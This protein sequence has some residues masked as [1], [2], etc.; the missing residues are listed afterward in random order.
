[1]NKTHFPHTKNP[2]LSILKAPEVFLARE[3]A[4]LLES[5]IE[6][7]HR[8]FPMAWAHRERFPY[9]RHLFFR[10][11]NLAVEIRRNVAYC[12][13]KESETNEALNQAIYDMINRRFSGANCFW[14][15][16]EPIPAIIVLKKWTKP[17]FRTEDVKV[18][19][20][21]LLFK[22][23]ILD[24]FV[25][26]HQ[27]DY[28]AFGPDMSSEGA[29]ALTGA[30]GEITLQLKDY[31]RSSVTHLADSRSITPRFRLEL[32]KDPEYY[33]RPTVEKQLTQYEAY[34]GTKLKTYL[35]NYLERE[36]SSFTQ[37][38]ISPIEFSLKNWLAHQALDRIST[39]E[40]SIV[41]EDSD[42]FAIFSNALLLF[43]EYKGDILA[44]E[45]EN[46]D[47]SLTNHLT[48]PLRNFLDETLHGLIAPYFLTKYYEDSRD[49]LFEFYQSSDTV[50]LKQTE[51][52]ISDLESD[53]QDAKME[54]S[55]L[56]QLLL[57]AN[58][59]LE[60]RLK[61]ETKQL[62]EVAVKEAQQAQKLQAE[63][64]KANRTIKQ[65]TE[66][67]ESLQ[68]GLD[69][70][71]SQIQTN[72]TLEMLDP[73][74]LDKT[75]LFVGGSPNLVKKMK[76]RWPDCR[77]YELAETVSPEFLRGSRYIFVLVEMVNHPMVREARL[78]SPQAKVS[79]V[80][81]TNLD[82]IGSTVR[83]LMSA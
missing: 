47:N 65:L 9:F 10:D 55:A 83:Q 43:G 30:L 52:K 78:A 8:R 68:T 57:R 66:Q 37:E 79:I 2:E 3:F 31:E 64:E 82:R 39:K 6:G 29:E 14:R 33:F 59:E 23:S 18:P 20:L 67:K 40:Q 48:S 17:L 26:R 51:Q 42:A 45:N 46:Y 72:E 13:L 62:K 27:I 38:T 22:I 25:L 28:R 15:G 24:Y 75:V 74:Y 35:Q 80:D 16:K 69:L 34:L 50:S 53:F 58:Q 81:A 56:K 36:P 32:L 4:T 19:I 49:K 60:S 71:M 7:L 70:A 21:E 77:Y 44:Q 1:M 41:I 54:V 73:V 76:K 12:L 5:Q 61:K 11:T 63:L